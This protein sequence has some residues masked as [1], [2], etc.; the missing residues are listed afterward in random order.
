MEQA[1]M[2]KLVADDGTLAF[3]MKELMTVFQK[4]HGMDHDIRLPTKGYFDISK[5]KIT[6]R[7]I[8]KARSLLLQ[9]KRL[10]NLPNKIE[11]Q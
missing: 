10:R 6:C 1:Y 8:P 9:H 2:K 5:K 4:I 11:L 3:A 7:A